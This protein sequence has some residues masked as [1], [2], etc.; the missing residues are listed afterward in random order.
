VIKGIKKPRI[1]ALPAEI[2]GYAENPGVKMDH[3]QCRNNGNGSWKP[4][5]QV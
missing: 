4:G 2:D 3:R 5:T 1:T